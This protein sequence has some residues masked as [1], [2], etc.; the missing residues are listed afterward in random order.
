MNTTFR[1]TGKTFCLHFT[2]FLQQ[3][4]SDDEPD[5]RG[6]DETFEGEISDSKITDNK[7]FEAAGKT[8][9]DENNHGNSLEGPKS[10]VE[11]AKVRISGDDMIN[12][13]G[14][15]T[16]LNKYINVLSIVWQPLPV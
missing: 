8:S 7:V 1:L 4:A 12:L 16:K 3:D 5:R 14:V 11:T 13:R 9:V 6:K 15:S 10:Q 2:K